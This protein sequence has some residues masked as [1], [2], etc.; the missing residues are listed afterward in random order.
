MIPGTAAFVP[1][2]GVQPAHRVPSAL[3]AVEGVTAPPEPPSS[4]AA[5]ALAGLGLGAAAA[6]VG[7]RG[8]QRNQ[9]ATRPT[10][11]AM[12]DKAESRQVDVTREARGGAFD[13]SAQIGACAPLGFW[14]PAGFCKDGKEET[15]LDLRGKELKHGRVAMMCIICFLG[16]H[17]CR[18][19][20]FENVTDGV[21]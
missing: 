19:P 15:F 2:G 8:R 12:G 11:N 16:Q 13:P 10:C 18:F 17:F 5:C 6:T 7:V 3:T 14:D 20:G 1:L 21:G 4:W 9:R